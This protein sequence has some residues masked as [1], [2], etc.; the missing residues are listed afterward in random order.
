MLGQEVLD[1]LSGFNILMVLSR[2]TRILRQQKIL[3]G[4]SLPKK[5]LAT[6]E[7]QETFREVPVQNMEG[8]IFIS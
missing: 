7:I 6:L 2:A 1:I 5:Y 3:K 4:V 8:P